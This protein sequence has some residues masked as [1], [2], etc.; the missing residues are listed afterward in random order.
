MPRLQ[1]LGRTPELH[2]R[3]L[4]GLVV[5]LVVLLVQVV[6]LMLQRLQ[7]CSELNYSTSVSAGETQIR[8]DGCRSCIEQRAVRITCMACMFML[9]P[10]LGFRVFSLVAFNGPIKHAA[11][12]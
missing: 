12:M 11:Y 10:G 2:C 6:A 4:L 8:S 5:H 9:L 3:Q 1:V 7:Y